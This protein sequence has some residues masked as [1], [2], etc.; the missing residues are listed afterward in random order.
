MTLLQKPPAK[1]LIINIFGIG[2]VLFTMPLVHNVKANFPQVQIDYVANQRAA[3]MLEEQTIINNVYVYERDEFK[4]LYDRSKISFYKEIRAFLKKL[5][6]VQYDMVFDFSLN[7][8][9][10]FFTWLIGIKKRIGFNFRNRSPLLTT[11]V[12]FQGFEDRHVVEHYLDILKILGWNTKTHQM[13]LEVSERDRQWAKEFLQNHE[14]NKDTKLVGI[15]PGAG[16]SW[17]E[18]AVFRRWSAEKYAKLADKIVEKF[19]AKIILMGDKKEQELCFKL[20]RAVGKA[21]IP[22]HGQTTLG[23]LA[24]LLECCR[25]VVLNDGGPLH[26][27]VAVGTNTVSIFGPVDEH[28]YGP[29]ICEQTKGRHVVVARQLPCRP[30][31]RKF[32][33]TR[34]EHIACLEQMGVE[35]V[36][37]RM[38]EFL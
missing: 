28:V 26:M 27:A 24:A 7:P 17:G 22:A 8:T 21:V 16:S 18:N 9:I 35:D 1:I 13:T 5:K 30:C 34:C 33:M 37:Q 14:I 32:K 20:E 15:M 10:N 3:P 38:E 19:S 11:K 29:Y 2:D 25:V 6:K 4:K 36:L 31:Y 23:Q 12:P